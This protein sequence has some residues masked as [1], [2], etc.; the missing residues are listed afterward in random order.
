MLKIVFRPDPC[1]DLSRASNLDDRSCVNCLRSCPAAVCFVSWKVWISA[2]RLLAVTVVLYSGMGSGPVA[3]KMSAIRPGVKATTPCIGAPFGVIPA[4]CTIWMAVRALV[5]KSGE[6]FE[7][8]RPQP[9]CST[10]RTGHH[11]ALLGGSV[12]VKL[13]F[14]KVMPCF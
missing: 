4:D 2:S 7:S 5:G 1:S 14:G 6:R 12:T 9:Y 10:H 13:Q 8:R 11:H 3:C